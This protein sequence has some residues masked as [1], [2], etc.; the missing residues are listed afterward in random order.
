MRSQTF[1]NWLTGILLLVIAALGF[2]SSYLA[3]AD[4]AQQHKF[5]LPAVFPLILEGGMIVFSLAALRASLHAERAA[6]PWVLVIGS[7]AMALVFNVIHAQAYGYLAMFMASTPSLFLLLS[8]ETFMGQI[9]AGVRRKGV[10][11]SITALVHQREQLAADL[12]QQQADFEQT[13]T[14]YQLERERLEAK[15]AELKTEIGDLRKEKRAYTE[16]SD[17][18]R[19]KALEI[20][21]KRPDISGADLGRALSRSESLGGK[22]KRELLAVNGNGKTS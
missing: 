21:S 12:E 11:H 16:V 20:L 13:K 18:T 22:L 2:A 19:A 15:I 14:D 1:I 7:S 17:N 6:W 3:L 4:L 9:K 10:V 8:F 5:T